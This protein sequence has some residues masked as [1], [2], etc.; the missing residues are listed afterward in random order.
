VSADDFFTGMFVTALGP[1]DVLTEV[2]VPVLGPGTGAAYEKFSHPASRYAVVGVA[3]VISVSVGVCKSAHVAVTGAMPSA[4][5]LTGLESALTGVA[6]DE[7]AI[8]K[9]CRGLVDT[10]TLLSDTFAS[11]EYRGHLVDVL[12]RR[13]VG[14]AAARARA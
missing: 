2:H 12:A 7:A 9:A 10:A 4:R 3:V 14:R 13:A 5:R 6:L 11:A 8:V 1:G